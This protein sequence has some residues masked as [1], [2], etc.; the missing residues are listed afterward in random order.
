MIRH[1]F[2]LVCGV[3][4][5]STAVIMIKECSV[6]PVLLAAFRLA[7]AVIVLSPFFLR[8][9]ARHRG[10]FGKRELRMSLLPG[11]LLAV[12]FITWIIAARMTSAANASL[13]VNL[14]PVVM[15][16]LLVVL[17]G[18]R[19]TPGE[20]SGTALA[21]IGLLMLSLVDFHLNKTHFAGDMLCFFSMLFF[22]VYLALARKNRKHVP[23]VW[24]YLVPLY[25]LAAVFCF[26]AALF[27]V[28]PIQVYS[29]KDVTMILGLGLLPTVIGHTTLN[30]SLKHVRGQVVSI[31]NMGQFVFAGIMA[32]LLLNETPRLV[33]YPASALLMAGAILA[34][35]AA[36]RKPLRQPA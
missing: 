5:C 14:V 21:M 35:R 36:P 1:L 23:T 13:I 33:F 24:L 18:E 28:N 3:F 32:F 11:L 26:I 19:I 15:P 17:V 31:V 7:V 8:D 6:D 22:A 30:Y 2:I 12:H 25:A 20:L 4:F 10:A 27:R 9:V 29:M 16:F 34:V